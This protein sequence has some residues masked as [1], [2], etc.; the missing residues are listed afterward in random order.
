MNHQPSRL[1]LPAALF[2]LLSAAMLCAHSTGLAG[3]GF[4]SI[5][6]FTSVAATAGTEVEKPDG[7]INQFHRAGSFTLVPLGKPSHG[8][9][10]SP[11]PVLAR[12]FNASQARAPPLS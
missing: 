6:P 3:K 1:L 7:Y 8:L 12:V 5:D 4:A 11:F 2:V 9:A 10:H